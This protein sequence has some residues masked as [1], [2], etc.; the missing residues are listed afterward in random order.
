M[1]LYTGEVV[2]LVVLVGGGR[3]S[4]FV[5][6]CVKG[7]ERVVGIDICYRSTGLDK[8]YGIFRGNWQ[9]FAD[10]GRKMSAVQ[11]ANNEKS[12]DSKDAVFDESSR[13]RITS[14]V[15]MS[16]VGGQSSPNMAVSFCAHCAC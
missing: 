2:L 1:L 16:F 7:L 15:G 9:V 8:P 6:F 3:F 10:G 13:T 4:L 11:K 14:L 5:V 12:E